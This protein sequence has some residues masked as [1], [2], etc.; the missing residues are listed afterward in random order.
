MSDLD[1]TVENSRLK[2][3]LIDFALQNSDLR[4][5]LDKAQTEA[6]EYKA[7]FIARSRSVECLSCKNGHNMV[8]MSRDYRGDVWRCNKCG[9]DFHISAVLHDMLKKDENE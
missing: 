3:A 7:A 6:R 2:D 4:R 8:F 5:E 1:T 9:G